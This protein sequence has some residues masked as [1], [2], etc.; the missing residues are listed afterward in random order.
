MAGVLETVTVSV[1]VPPAPVGGQRPLYSG[2]TTPLNAGHDGFEYRIRGAGGV[3]NPYW[4]SFAQ[5]P[6]VLDNGANETP[7]TAQPITL[8]CEIA[9]RV[10]KR[11]DR[12]WYQFAAKKGEVYVF[13]LASERIGAPTDMVMSIRNA[14]TKQALAEAD[15]DADVLHPAKF[16]NRSNDPPRLRFQAPEDG[17]YLLLVRSQDADH[18][19]G[20]RHLYRVTIAPEKPDFRLFVMPAA[21]NRPEVCRVSRGGE[22]A[23]TILAERTDGFSE[24]IQLAVEGL[25]PGVTCPAQSMGPEIRQ[26]SL[27]I[28][29]TPAA[30]TGHYEIKIKG[31]ATHNNQAAT[32]EA[33]PLSICWPTPPQSNLPTLSRVDRNLFLA[34]NDAAPFHLTAALPKPTVLQGE[35]VNVALKLNRLW[36]DFKTPLQVQQPDPPRIRNQPVMTLAPVTMNPGKDEMTAVLDV[37]STAPPGTYTLA[38]YGIGQMPYNKDPMAKQKP[39]INVVQPSTPITFLVVP[40]QLANVKLGT[41]T[42]QA[43]VGASAELL[44]QLTRQHGYRGPFKVQLIPPPNFKG[45]E[46][47]EATIPADQNEIKLGIKVAAMTPPGNHA[48]FVVRATALYEGKVP[49]AQEA[50]FGLNVTK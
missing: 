15:D 16:F 33:R 31:T 2:L 10:E 37:R 26:M 46:S 12:D 23:L 13:D 48:N 17:K 41:G 11:R 6:V 25:P 8:P 32:R 45:V 1:G 21:D 28:S 43:K 7:A 42:V 40:R 19:A 20:P 44:V 29:A 4:L 34:I 39:N 3:S 49:V 5:A 47:V 27:I 22:Q 36:P 30:P 18:N 24:P 38:F 35:K 14:A 9:G 50:K